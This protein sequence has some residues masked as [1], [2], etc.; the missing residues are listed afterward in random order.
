MT[1][2]SSAATKDPAVETIRWVPMDKNNPNHVDNFKELFRPILENTFFSMQQITNQHLLA[3]LQIDT[4]LPYFVVRGK[5]ELV[6][7]VVFFNV[8]WIDGTAELGASL[9]PEKQGEGQASIAKNNILGAIKLGVEKLGL[10]RIYLN[11]LD[12]GPGHKVVEGA[13]LFKEGTL[14]K[15]RRDGDSYRD[16]HLYAWVEGEDNGSRTSTDSG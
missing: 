12:G 1:E 10:R 15:A 8:N 2:S 6:G 7:L 16:A 13:G 14:R 3:P 9:F 5:D 4:T 11:V